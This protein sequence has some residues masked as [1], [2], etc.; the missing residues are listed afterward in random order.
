MKTDSY[1]TA[2]SELI[3][4]LESIY[5]MRNEVN[6]K[7]IIDMPM[8]DI[9]AYFNKEIGS[10]DKAKISKKN[11]DAGKT[12][13][14]L[15]YLSARMKFY[16]KKRL[17]YAKYLNMKTIANVLITFTKV[18]NL[19]SK[20]LRSINKVIELLVNIDKKFV[21][22]RNGLAYRYLR[23][24]VICVMHGNYANASIVADFIL[25]Q[26]IIKEDIG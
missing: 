20:T 25:Q 7:K 8:T 11:Q 15:S 26:F 5:G 24:F 16:N 4:K 3:I 1:I 23:I 6:G 21:A 22:F 14:S 10:A 2:L 13:V 19:N 12:L 18:S 17:D 9:I